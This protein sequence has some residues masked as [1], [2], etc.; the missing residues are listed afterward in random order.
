MESIELSKRFDHGEE[1][2][3]CNEVTGR[4]VVAVLKPSG[5]YSLF[6]VFTHISYFCLF[7]ASFLAILYVIL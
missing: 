4:L 7:L 3:N 2:V 5:L 1:S 6:F